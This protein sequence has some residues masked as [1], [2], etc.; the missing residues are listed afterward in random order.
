MWQALPVNLLSGLRAL[1]LQGPWARERRCVTISFP[2]YRSCNLVISFLQGLT[3]DD[4]PGQS[5]PNSAFLW[6]QPSAC[7]FRAGPSQG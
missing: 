7:G 1:C 5:L 4:H 2:N 3:T 6:A